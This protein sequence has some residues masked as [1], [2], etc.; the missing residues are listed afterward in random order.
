MK[1]AAL[2]F[3]LISTV[4]VA[5]SF[6]TPETNSHNHLDIITNAGLNADGGAGQKT[7]PMGKKLD[8]FGTSDQFSSSANQ[9]N[10]F[11]SD[12]QSTRSSIKLD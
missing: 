3:A 2:T 11:N 7:T 9:L 12:S 5:T 10:S 4:M 8:L 6:A 1:K